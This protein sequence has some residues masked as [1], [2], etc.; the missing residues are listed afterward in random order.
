[1]LWVVGGEA[2]VLASKDGGTFYVNVEGS[3]GMEASLEGS[4]HASNASSTSQ[5]LESGYAYSAGAGPISVIRNKTF[6][7]GAATVS[8][9]AL[10]ASG[11][12]TAN[13]KIYTKRLWNNDD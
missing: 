1:M 10:P 13:T 3:V 8:A 11:S 4:V 9:S 2:D 12:I 6:A 7:S 5:F